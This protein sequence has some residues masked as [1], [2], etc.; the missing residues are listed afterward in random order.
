MLVRRFRVYN[1]G[2][3]VD[4]AR[5]ILTVIMMSNDENALSWSRNSLP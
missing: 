5:E 3:K 1:A 4:A 2:L